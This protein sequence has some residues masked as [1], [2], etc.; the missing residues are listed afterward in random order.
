M[1]NYLS[2]SLAIS[3]LTTPPELISERIGLAPTSTRLRG[4]PTKTGASRLPEFDV[5]EY[6]I[7]AELELAPGD[8][9]ED[10]QPSFI[11]E[12]LNKISVACN[13]IRKLADTEDVKIIFVYHMDRMPYVGLSSSHV[14]MIAALGASIDFDMMIG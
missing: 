3:S 5:H 9:I 8:V 10:L 11:M 2:M 12:F 7:R 13:Q 14:E 1:K 6:W 4:T